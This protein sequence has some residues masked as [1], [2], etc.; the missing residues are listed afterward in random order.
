MTFTDGSTVLCAAVPVTITQQFVGFLCTATFAAGSHTLTAAY[1]GEPIATANSISRTV[2]VAA[3]A[4]AASP[5][6]ALSHLG[7]FG[8]ILGMLL[9]G[10]L[11][12]PR[13]SELFWERE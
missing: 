7:I 12:L 5:A 2:E 1:S 6:P 9:L 10:L 13:P 8:L 11:L 3:A 4:G